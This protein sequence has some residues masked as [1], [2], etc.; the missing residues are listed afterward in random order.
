MEGAL[1]KMS[2]LHTTRKNYQ[3]YTHME[4][5]VNRKQTLN[6]YTVMNLINAEKHFHYLSQESFQ[7]YN[8]GTDASNI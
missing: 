5:N 7:R 6:I 8:S 2:S 3:D 1:N 4:N